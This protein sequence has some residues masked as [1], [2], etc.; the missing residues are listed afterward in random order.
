MFLIHFGPQQ[1]LIHKA[2]PLVILW[3]ANLCSALGP[4]SLPRVGMDRA[5]CA[6]A[7]AARPAC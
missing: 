2:S 4:A 1:G 3:V 6:L 5:G 7:V